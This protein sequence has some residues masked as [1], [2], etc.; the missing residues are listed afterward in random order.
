MKKVVKLNESDLLKIVNK[1]IKEKKNIVNE[2]TVGLEPVLGP[3]IGTGTF[4]FDKGATVPNAWNKQKITDAMRKNLVA[5]VSEC[6]DFNFNAIEKFF[7]DKVNKLPKFIKIMVKTDATGSDAENAAVGQGRLDY[8]TKLVEE[9]FLK[10]GYRADMAKS[11]VITNSDES[12]KPANVNRNLKDPSKVPGDPLLR[13]ARVLLYQVEVRG[14]DT[15]GIQNVQGQLNAASSIM[16]TGFMDFVDEDQIVTAIS[17]IETYSDILD[18]NDAIAAQR[19]SRFSSLEGFLNSQLFDDGDAM[20]TVARMLDDACV[21]SNLPRET[22]RVVGDKISIPLK[23]KS[24][25]R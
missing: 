6:I 15:K 25:M 9:A 17:Q 12:Y 3:A 24:R 5:A 7:D 8:F 20:Q 10:A 22:V 21:A 11:F 18:L 14:L 16:N 13:S 2:A 4:F 23:S 1:V 19:D